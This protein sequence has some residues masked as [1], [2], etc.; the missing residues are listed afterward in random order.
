[1]ARSSAWEQRL[2]EECK[3]FNRRCPVG[4]AVRYW[5]F[6]REGEGISSVLQS[7]AFI[8][9]RQRY[10]QAFLAVHVAGSQVGP[11]PLVNVQVEH[12]P[13]GYVEAE[14]VEVAEL[15]AQF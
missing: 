11:I 3:D 13:R 10:A 15:H 14:L 4:T 7:P 2:Q 12:A 5:I 1:M 9:G 6:R 8:T